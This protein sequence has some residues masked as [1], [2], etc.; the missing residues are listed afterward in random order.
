MKIRKI[1]SLTAA[2]SFIMMLLTSFILYIVPQGRIANWADWHLLGLSKEQWGNIHINTGILFLIAL[3]FHIYYNWKLIMSY[4]KDKAKNL[5]VFTKEFNIA[6]FLIFLI[7]LGTYFEVPPFS[8]ILGLSESI[9]DDAAEKYGE[10]PY[11]HAELSSLKTF[12]KKMGIDL[13]E[14]MK[15]LKE[16][17]FT[18]E[19]ETQTLSAIGK[20]ND[21][22][23][24]QIY[25]TIKPSGRKSATYSVVAKKLPDSPPSGTGN[26][27][28]ADLCSQYNLNM[29]IILRALAKENINASEDLTIKKIAEENQIG[30]TDLYERIKIIASTN[31]NDH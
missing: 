19:G 12:A 23:P 8:S 11:G 30:S 15:L 28:L 2:L 9:K 4:L 18:V 26:M 31:S 7:G 10:P 20:L 25:L 17:G 14:S 27:T 29:K 21:I 3:G 16:A 13:K 1:A 5:K 6:L 24:Q 22:S